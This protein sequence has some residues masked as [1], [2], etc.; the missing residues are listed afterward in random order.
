MYARRIIGSSVHFYGIRKSGR[1]R[2]IGNGYPSNG[3]LAAPLDPETRRPRREVLF[4]LDAQ[5]DHSHGK[6]T[7]INCVL[8][9]SLFLLNV[10]NYYHA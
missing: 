4:G 10:M 7:I 1:I 2:E 6:S 8:E 9:L 5:K 3:G